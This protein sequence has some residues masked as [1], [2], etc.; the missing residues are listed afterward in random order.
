MEATAD[1]VISSAKR[2]KKRATAAIPS[3]LPLTSSRLHSDAANSHRE[4]YSLYNL[5]RNEYLMLITQLIF[6]LLKVNFSQNLK[7]Y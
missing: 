1:A 6:Y 7:F 3:E 5:S 4:F 2:R